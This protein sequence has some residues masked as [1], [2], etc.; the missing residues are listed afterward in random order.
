MPNPA[1][2]SVSAVPGPSPQDIDLRLLEMEYEYVTNSSFHTDDLRDKFIQYYLIIV[3]VALTLIIGLIENTRVDVAIFAVISL[4]LFAIG[5]VLMFILV[6]LR[7]IVWECIAATS[8]IKE[9]YKKHATHAQDLEHAL[10]WDE[11]SMPSEKWHSVTSLLALLVAILDSTMLGSAL[12]LMIARPDL[13]ANSL[14]DPLGRAILPAIGL[15][16]ASAAIQWVVY[17]R[18]LKW[19]NDQA[20]T[21]TRLPDKM[22]YWGIDFEPGDNSSTRTN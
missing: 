9:Y 20:K 17:F 21:S 2:T 1:I 11:G 16:A 12:F 8:L 15:F 22:K 13:N 3:S 18:R 14:P 10:L 6:R 7:R 5:L 4:V 19:E